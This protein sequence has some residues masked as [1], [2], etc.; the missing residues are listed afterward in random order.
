MVRAAADYGL[1][2]IAEAASHGVNI[3]APMRGVRAERGKGGGYRRLGTVE[4]GNEKRLLSPG[5]SLNG[6]YE[7]QLC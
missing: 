7:S 4:T 2:E 5:P 3:S 6:Y 1:R